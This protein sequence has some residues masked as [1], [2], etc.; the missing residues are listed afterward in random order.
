MYQATHL[1]LLHTAQH[2]RPKNLAAS[3]LL[4]KKLTYDI[5]RQTKTMATSFDN[6]AK[7]CYDFIVP[8][9][10]IM[11][12]QRLGLPKKAAKMIT[13]VLQKTKY[14]L[15]TAHGIAQTTYQSTLLHRIL[16]VGQG[17]GSA[18]CIWNTLLDTILWSVS[19][20]YDSLI[21]ETPTKQLIKD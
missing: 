19:D 7:G 16:G 13:T 3:A 12:C 17:S 20:K 15:K 10:T 21:L 9:H 11:A 6:N 14:L 18:S 1:N 4:N 8:P 5:I 2:A